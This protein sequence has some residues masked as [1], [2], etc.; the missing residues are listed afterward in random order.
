MMSMTKDER[1]TATRDRALDEQ[2]V[3]TMAEN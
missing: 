3:D 2:S 1:M